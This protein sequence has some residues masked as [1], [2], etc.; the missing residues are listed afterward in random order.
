MKNNN[1]VKSLKVTFHPT[2]NMSCFYFGE[3]NYILVNRKL[4]LNILVSFELL[5][6]SLEKQS[7]IYTIYLYLFCRKILIANYFFARSFSTNFL[8]QRFLYCITQ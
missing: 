6:M 2:E 7:I 4:V 8:C 5:V 3:L 1:Y